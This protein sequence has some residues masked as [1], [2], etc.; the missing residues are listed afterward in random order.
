MGLIQ[1]LLSE[2]SNGIFDGKTHIDDSRQASQ[3]EKAYQKLGKI[4][5]PNLTIRKGYDPD[6]R[7]NL[8][9]AYEDPTDLHFRYVEDTGEFFY[10]AKIFN[11]ILS[12]PEVQKLVGKHINPNPIGTFIVYGGNT[13]KLNI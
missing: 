1:A 3:F 8:T 11:K 7:M 2:T 13:N 5:Y 4:V 12:N 9:L 6:L 10:D